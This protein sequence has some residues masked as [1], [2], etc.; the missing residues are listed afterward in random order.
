MD[1]HKYVEKRASKEK[2][3]LRG[4]MPPGVLFA[5]YDSQ[6]G[7]PDY[8]PPEYIDIPDLLSSVSTHPPME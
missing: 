2:T 3:G 5:V 1:V 4:P 8:I 6:T 7:N